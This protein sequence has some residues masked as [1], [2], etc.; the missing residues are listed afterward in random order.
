[1][2]NAARRGRIPAERERGTD[3]ID[4]D[5]GIGASLLESV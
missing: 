3:D 4:S 5:Q 2:A 1:M